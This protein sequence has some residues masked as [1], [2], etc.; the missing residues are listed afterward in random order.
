MRNLTASNLEAEDRIAPTEQRLAQQ[1][2]PRLQGSDSSEES[3]VLAVESIRSSGTQQTTTLLINK[4][5]R[6]EISTREITLERDGL[7]SLENEITLERDK[8]RRLENE[9]ALDRDKLRDLENEV[10]LAR[11]KLRK[12]ETST[13]E[14][15]LQS[16]KLRG[17]LDASRRQLEAARMNSATLER[18]MRDLHLKMSEGAQDLKRQVTDLNAKVQDHESGRAHAQAYQNGMMY[19][20]QSQHATEERTIFMQQIAAYKAEADKW[21]MEAFGQGSAAISQCWQ[22]SVDEAVRRER[23]KDAFVMKVLRDQLAALKSKKEG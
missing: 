16:N 14:N 3:F 19:T 15:A 12:F 20:I 23:E 10:V 13:H 2:R 7:R 4:V 11:D 22:A 21:R 9:N 6:L 18:Q 8:S 1:A 5:A 17:E